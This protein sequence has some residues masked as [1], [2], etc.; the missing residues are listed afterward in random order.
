MCLICVDLAKGKLTA[1]E[2]KGN[3]KEM[4]E[5]I[6]DDHFLEVLDLIDDIENKETE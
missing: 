4:I 5:D 2:A 3:L 6:S 1:K